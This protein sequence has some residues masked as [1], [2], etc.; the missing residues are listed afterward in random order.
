LEDVPTPRSND[1]GDEGSHQ[2]PRVRV[3][4]APFV[5]FLLRGFPGR[6]KVRLTNHAHGSDVTPRPCAPRVRRLQAW[7]PRPST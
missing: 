3:S 5:T 2:G 7:R 4:G 6:R 1:T